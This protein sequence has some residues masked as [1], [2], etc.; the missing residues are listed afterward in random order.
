M[1]LSHYQK[2]ILIVSSGLTPQ[3][4]TETLYAL[5][6][7]PSEPF[8]PTEIH[9]ITTHRGAETAKQTLLNKKNGWYYQFVKQFNLPQM[10]FSPRH[11][12]IIKTPEYELSDIRTPFDNE[13]TA[14][15]ITEFIRK[16]C[17]QENTALHV[18]IAGGRKTMGFYLGYALSLFGRQQDRLSHVLVAEEYES[19]ADFYFPTTASEQKSN[20]SKSIITLANIPFLRINDHQPQSIIEGKTY[21]ETI[22]EIQKQLKPATLFID[23]DKKLIYTNHHPIKLPLSLFSFYIWVLNRT[24]DNNLIISPVAEGFNMPYAEEFLR[25]YKQSKGEIGDTDRTVAA[26]KYGMSQSYIYAKVGDIKRKLRYLLGS[27]GSQQFLIKSMH[28]PRK[29]FIAIDKKHIRWIK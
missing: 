28:Q 12:H 4:L 7:D 19:Q 20:H 26:L 15:Y 9:L 10:R 1:Q 16:F 13:I 27:M 22:K 6:T 17:Q 24:L 5:I 29:Y 21:T 8:I 11:I 2:R 3:V 18:S 23:M 14:D 25:Y